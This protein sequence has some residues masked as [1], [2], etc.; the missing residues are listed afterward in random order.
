MKK[1][2]SFKIETLLFGI[3]NPKGAIEQVLFAKTVA[4][5][6]GIE[7]FNCLACLTFTDPTINKAFSGGL[8]MDETL[9]IGYEGWSDAILHLC[10]KSG[11]STLKVATGYL[12][13]KEDTIHSEYRNDILLRKLSDKE[14]KE[15]FTHVWNNLDEIRP[16]P[17]LTKE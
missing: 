7:P 5:H 11:Q 16:N 6:E 3:E 14:I 1:K 12:L 15:I 17:R 2:F 13:S 9:L 8:P 4:T 10:I